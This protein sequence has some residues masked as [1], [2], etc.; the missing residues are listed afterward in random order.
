MLITIAS[1]YA[2]F[3]FVASIL[4]LATIRLS[5]QISQQEQLQTATIIVKE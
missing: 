1:I 2:S 5:S 3:S 4:L